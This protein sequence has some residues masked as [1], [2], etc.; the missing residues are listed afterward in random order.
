M[1]PPARPLPDD[2]IP[3]ILVRLAPDDPA[4]VVRAAAVCKAWRRVLAAPTFSARYRA[5]H[6]SAPVLGFIH[7][8]IDLQEARFIPTPTTSFRPSP[9]SVR[10]RHHAL[11]CRHGRALFYDYD[12][13]CNS[14]ATA[15]FV[16]WDP[17]TGGHHSIPEAPDPWT[18]PVVLCAAAA[19]G[20][21]HRGCCGGG[22]PSPF[23][24]A[25][26]GV[27]D[28]EDGYSDFHAA[29]Y[30]SETGRWSM[31]LYIHLGHRTRRGVTW[32]RIGRR[33]T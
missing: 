33:R 25:I 8:P 3:D 1:A 19:A 29:L 13:S 12:S 17:V 28:T 31:G 5:L 16:V 30:S 24:V 21:D 23:I 32:W 20:C 2:L 27:E 18:N 9:S 4:G 11:D 14:T 22:S 6:P 26:A 15:G 7:R 10:R